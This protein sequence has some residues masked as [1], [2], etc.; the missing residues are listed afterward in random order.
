M[1]WAL[2]CFYVSFVVVVF[3]IKLFWRIILFSSSVC[4]ITDASAK[5][6]CL[7]KIKIDWAAELFCF[8]FTLEKWRIE[9]EGVRL[10]IGIHI[11]FSLQNFKHVQIWPFLII[12]DH[13]WPFLSKNSDSSSN[14]E[15][16]ASVKGHTLESKIDVG[17][18]INIEPGNFDKKNKCRALNKHRVWTFCQK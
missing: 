3:Y 6:F 4:Y 7:R 10:L 13:F 15:L 1:E 11:K 2:V 17:Q 12:F 5:Y 8:Y 9:I 14:I 16:K 18:G